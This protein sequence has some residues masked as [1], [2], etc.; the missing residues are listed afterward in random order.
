MLSR[1]EVTFPGVPAFAVRGQ[2]HALPARRDA[3][4]LLGRA[5]GR[6]T[7]ALSTFRRPLTWDPRSLLIHTRGSDPLMLVHSQVQ[8]GAWGDGKGFRGPLITRQLAQT[9]GCGGAGGN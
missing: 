9:E 2:L 7:R 3:T 1:A 4:G 6:H 8:Y 5:T